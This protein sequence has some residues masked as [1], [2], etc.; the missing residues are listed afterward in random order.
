MPI[1]R[2]ATRGF[3]VAG[4]VAVAC[5]EP[6]PPRYPVPSPPG[7]PFP[8]RCRALPGAV[9]APPSPFD[10]DETLSNWPHRHGVF[11][12]ARPIT[13]KSIPAKDVRARWTKAQSEEIPNRQRA[14]G[15]ALVALGG[16]YWQRTKYPIAASAWVSSG[17][18]RGL[19]PARDELEGSMWRELTIEGDTL[20]VSVGG[21]DDPSVGVELLV[22]TNDPSELAGCNAPASARPAIEGHERYVP[23]FVVR[24]RNEA[25]EARDLPMNGP[26]CALKGRRAVLRVFDFS[27]TAHVNVGRI[28]WGDS[29]SR[30]AIHDHPA[31][32]GVADFH[33]HPMS[34][35]G[36][37]GL[38]GI[39]T[40]W[41][42]PGGSISDYR[43]PRS[44]RAKSNI[45]RDIPS[46]DNVGDKHNRYNTHHGGF[47]A[48]TMINVAEGRASEDTEDLKL[49]ILADDHGK[50]G[51]PSFKSYPDFRRGSHQVQHITQ[52]HRA[53]LGGLRLMTALALQN[54]GLEYGMGWVECGKSGW[55]TVETTQDLS[56]LRASVQGMRELA[57]LNKEWMEIAY[58]PEQAR[59]IIAQN[60]LAVVLGVEV[61]QL[62]QEGR[63]VI[64]EVDELRKLGVR[65]VIVIH[66]MDN[67]LGGSAIFQDL[68]DTVGDWLN[69]PP[70]SRDW[71]RGLSGALDVYGDTEP[72]AF[73]D[74][75][76][77]PLADQERIMYRLG[78]PR[79]IVLSDVYPHPG[80]STHVFKLTGPAGPLHPFVSTHPVFDKP[81]GPY[82]GLPP[83]F[84]N[85][86]GLTDRGREFVARLMQRGLLVDVAHMSDAALRDTYA[87]GTSGGPGVTLEY[88]CGDYPLLVSH[89]HFRKLSVT[90]DDSAI[91]DGLIADTA[92]LVRPLVAAALQKHVDNPMSECI[93]DDSKCDAQVLAKARAA[94]GHAVPGVGTVFKGDLPREYDL[95]TQE[96]TEIARRK[97]AIGVFLGQNM[98]E[99]DSLWQL[100]A[101]AGGAGGPMFANDC[102][103]SSKGFAASL[104][105]AEDQGLGGIG[106]ASDFAFIR[107]VVPRFGPNACAAYL[108][109]GTGS[110]AA[111]QLL[112]TLINPGQFRFAAQ[113]D[114]VVYGDGRSIDGDK[115]DPYVM[116]ERTYD[117]NT[118]GLAHYGLIPD[119][120]QDVA[121]VVG[122]SH[123]STLDPLF[124]SAEAY[125]EM[126]EKARALAGCGAGNELCADD[127]LDA[128]DPDACGDACPHA[129]N[130]GAPLQAV[131]EVYGYCAPGRAIG[132]V[133]ERGAVALKHAQHGVDVRQRAHADELREQGDWAVFAT[134][135]DPHWT[136]GGGRSQALGCPPETNYVKVRRVL[137]ES[138]GDVERCDWDPVPPASGNRRVVFECLVGP[139][140]DRRWVTR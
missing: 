56:V 116:G 55:P 122:E 65:Q 63:S 14:G 130:G 80:R 35:M 26:R 133:S 78:S 135:A 107:S 30:A 31:V 103:G 61:P 92:D 100:N 82:D 18:E 90:T 128:P 138:I 6:V 36:F 54:Q 129:W 124:G 3:A 53:Y 79:R 89:A 22:E 29:A 28:D 52:I 70:E 126:W 21:D 99:T 76:T 10:L 51:G 16:S 57:A 125:I 121:N 96:V 71:V 9:T 91:G 88:G 64:D 69:R 50:H 13:A 102:A 117:F 8:W 25:I 68:Y 67:A 115:L 132:V 48:P 137:E 60:K 20:R 72:A 12:A 105:Y 47:A 1:S 98:L 113:T 75:T 134:G 73:F 49:P 41:G 34:F 110:G 17:Y 85:K 58:T 104:L 40:V 94:A 66:G 127:E 139:A 74:V 62:G 77:D 112:E 32:W 59:R 7:D 44:E 42:V 120:L 11:D 84:R 24:G 39:H 111:A 4:L 136:C 123:A 95:S 43:D 5:V 27:K 108:D 38:Q 118:D 81:H 46:C 106:I 86:R 37:G 83:G 87:P 33:T 93:H 2:H 101:A 109:A 19:G 23:V 45:T 15:G 97:G 114:P 119:M 131:A 140:E